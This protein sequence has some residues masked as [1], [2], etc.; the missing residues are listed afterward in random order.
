MKNSD[1]RSVGL[2][3]AGL[4]LVFGTAHAQVVVYDPTNYLQA[5]RQVAAWQQQYQQM[6][7]A[8]QTLQT[9]LQQAKTQYQSLTGSRNLGEILNNPLLKGVVPSDIASVYNQLNGRGTSGLTA[10][11]LSLRTQDAVYTCDNLSGELRTACEAALDAT[12]QAQAYQ[13]N[14]NTLLDERGQQLSDLQGQIN[15]TQDPKAIAELQARI[16]IAQAE[17]ANDANRIL[18]MN[19]MAQ[20]ETDAAQQALKER[21]LKRL[22]PDAPAVADSF[23]FQMPGQ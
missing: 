12:S 11:G 3:F 9:S 18:I 19:A 13:Q 1:T 14:A 8:I 21:T 23:V 15:G 16:Q 20:S 7:S 6:A 10:A 2:V 22:S 17:V 5:L 4:F